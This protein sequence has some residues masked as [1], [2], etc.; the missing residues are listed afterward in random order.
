MA[1][2]LEIESLPEPTVRYTL[3]TRLGAGIFGQV[4]EAA[5]K[6]AGG[7][8]VAIKIQSVNKDSEKCL[9][10]EYNILKDFCPGHSNLVDF[11]GI[12]C[13]KSS[14]DKKIWFVLEVGIDRI[15][16]YLE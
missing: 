2:S 1:D 8:K 11:Y 10:D 15:K 14:P 5:D 9:L 13:D 16:F 7:K 6:E 4:Y 3:G 12:F